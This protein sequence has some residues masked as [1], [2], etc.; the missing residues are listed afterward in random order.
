MAKTHIARYTPTTEELKED[1]R[2]TAQ[3]LRGAYDTFNF[4]TEPELV[5]AAIFEIRALNARYSYLLR[6]VKEVDGT[7]APSCIAAGAM[8]GGTLCQS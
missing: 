7:A 4:V 2:L 6:R 3:A 1:I 8:E 5:E